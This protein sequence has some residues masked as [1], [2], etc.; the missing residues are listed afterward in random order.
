MGGQGGGWQGTQFSPGGY[1]AFQ[2]SGHGGIARR[3]NVKGVPG[4]KNWLGYHIRHGYWDCGEGG[5]TIMMLPEMAMQLYQAGFK[6]KS[7]VYE[8]IYQQS[9]ITVG[10][11]RTHSW[12]DVRTNAWL[13]VERTSGKHWKELPEDYKIPAINDPFES[14]IIVTGGGE[15]VALFSG[16]RMPNMDPAYGIDAWR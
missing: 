15:E 9:Y 12:P 16:G 13:G 10:E 2:K 7:D 6:T 4:P 8:W 3:L 5:I 11:Y 1:R 14:C